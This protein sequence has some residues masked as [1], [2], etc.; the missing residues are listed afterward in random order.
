M[1]RDGR[2]APG[3]MATQLATAIAD[4]ALHAEAVQQL[5]GAV[6]VQQETQVRGTRSTR[7]CCA[8]IAIRLPAGLLGGEL[9]LLQQPLPPRLAGA[10]AGLQRQLPQGLARNLQALHLDVQGRQAV[11]VHIVRRCLVQAL[12]LGLGDRQVGQARKQ[13]PR[14][15]A[16]TG[17]AVFDIAAKLL[18]L[19]LTA[20]GVAA[21]HQ[22]GLDADQLTLAQ[23]QA[24]HAQLQALGQV[25]LHLCL[26]R[27]GAGA[28]AAARVQ[29][30]QPGIG[31]QRGPLH[32]R[33][34]PAVGQAL[35]GPVAQHDAPGKHPRRFDGH[36]LGIHHLA[37]PGHLHPQL[38]AMGGIQ[39]LR[40]FQPQAVLG[41][42][43]QRSRQAQGQTAQVRTHH[44][45]LLPLPGHHADAVGSPALGMLRQLRGHRQAAILLQSQG[46]GLPLGLDAHP[47]LH[48]GHAAV[49]LD[50]PAQ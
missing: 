43:V 25:A 41:R 12:R 34:H 18:G 19:Q 39:R 47:V 27:H 36:V 30:C 50:R 20:P 35:L 32:L 37:A 7:A 9:E 26:R 2:A 4:H 21:V 48:R 5:P 15:A 33:H 44:H 17:G 1:R 14:A 31:I 13:A 3:D 40:H 42:L 24:R 45:R 16:R 46:R 29:H 8:P 22:V 6:H 11:R 49:Q 38:L 23:Q 28:I 10:V